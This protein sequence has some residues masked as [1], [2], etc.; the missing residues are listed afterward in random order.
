MKYEL[1]L[2]GVGVLALLFAFL[3]SQQLKKKSMGNQKTAELSRLIQQGAKSYLTKQY[4]ILAVVAI[5]IAIILAV[6]INIQTAAAY[7]IGAALSSIAGISGMMVA[8][9]ANART[10]EGCRKSLNEGLQIA[11]SSGI[12]MGMTV[13]GLGLI[14]VIATYIMF[15]NLEVLFGFGFGAATIALFARVGGGIYTKA[16]DMGADLV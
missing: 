12:I 8:T 7:I 13:V 1:S 2:I 11:F 16:A 9:G 15:G 14:G 4:Q 5:I 3:L 6:A 10:T